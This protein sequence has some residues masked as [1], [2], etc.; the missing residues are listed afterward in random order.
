M[1]EQ[2]KILEK[3]RTEIDSIDK[4]LLQLIEKRSNLSSKIIKAKKGGD[5]FKPKREEALINKLLSRSKTSSPQFLEN[6]WRLLISEN[7]F[8]QGGLKISVGSSKKA[9]DTAEWHF[10]KAAQIK[11]FKTNVGAFKKITSGDYD[12]AVVLFENNLKETY[13]IDKVFIKR[14]AITPVISRDNFVKIAIYKKDNLNL[15]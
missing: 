2:N 5:I 12:A 9:F 4:N 15:G 10:G 1:N 6:I 13:S 3:L 8:L 14:L 11:L 7:L